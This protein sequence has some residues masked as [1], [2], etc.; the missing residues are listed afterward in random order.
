MAIA[1]VSTGAFGRRV[2]ELLSGYG[3]AGH[4]AHAHTLDEAFDL[5]D[6]VVVVVTWRPS[7][8]LCA[9]ADEL[10]FE[11]GKPWLPVVMEHWRI[12]IGPL[13]RPPVGPCYRCF[14]R[15]KAQHDSKHSE[16]VLADNA[17]SQDDAAGPQGFMPYHARMTVS[18]A[19]WLIRPDVASS[20][21]RGDGAEMSMS[22]LIAYD[23]V[24]SD[25]SYSGVMRCHGCGRCTG[26]A[27][28]E[29]EVGELL[30]YPDR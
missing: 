9:R 25:I 27:R 20:L 17:F 13:I 6:A 23:L 16:T 12:T 11:R 5:D 15:R 29:A 1:V 19:M 18:L 7:P 10:A 30:R 3:S 8:P 26:L 28:P 2:A 21:S 4:M 22:T 14:V 24:A